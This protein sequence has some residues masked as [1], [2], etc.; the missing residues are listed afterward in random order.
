M[1]PIAL[2]IFTA[3]IGTPSRLAQRG[4]PPES[5]IRSAGVALP[6]VAMASNEFCIVPPANQGAI[7]HEHRCARIR[8]LL[9]MH[10]NARFTAMALPSIVRV[11][12]TLHG[13]WKSKE[14]TSRCDGGRRVGKQHWTV[15]EAD[16]AGSRYCRCRGLA[17]RAA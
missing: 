1:T 12:R 7:C 13:R 2:S 15:A 3:E 5:M 4:L 6:G 11:F 16:D 10:Q 9:A 17:E 8:L 14:Q